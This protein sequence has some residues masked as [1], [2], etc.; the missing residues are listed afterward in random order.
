MAYV[1]FP[2]TGGLNTKAEPSSIADGQLAFAV[3]CSYDTVGAVSSG[4][5]R[6]VL[7]DGVA[8]AGDGTDQDIRGHFDAFGDRY[9]KSGTSV[10]K[11]Y[12]ESVVGAEGDW[13]G[14]THLTGFG[15]GQYVYLCGG[16]RTARIDP[17]DPDTPTTLETWGLV[18]PGYQELGA[19]PITITDLVPPL[20]NVTVTTPAAHGLSTYMRV[21]LFGLTDTNGIPNGELNGL[22]SIRVT[23]TT[24]YTFATTTTASAASVAGGGSAAFQKQAPTLASPAGGA[25]TEGTY[26]Y[27]YT[28]YNGMA[29][30]NFSAIMSE[31]AALNDLGRLTDILLG[32]EGT[33]ERRIYRSDVGGSQLYYVGTLSDNTTTTYDDLGAKPPHASASASPGDAVKDDSRPGGPSDEIRTL[34]VKGGFINR[35]N[36]GKPSKNVAAQEIVATNLGYLA[37]WTNHDAPP[38]DL[39]GVILVND[40]VIGISGNEVRFSAVGNPEHWPIENR[41]IPG[42]SDGETLL[43]VKAFDRDVIIYT[44]SGL[45]RLTQLGT[46]FE[47]SR[48]EAI[49]SPVGTT[50]K[51]GVAVLDGQQGHVFIANTGL[52]LFDGQR[53]QEA[54]LMFDTLFNG[55]RDP[56]FSTDTV[57]STYSDT[58]ILEALRD[59]VFVSYGNTSANSRLLIVDYENIQDPKATIVRQALTT[60]VR[61]RASNKLIGG[62]SSGKLYEMDY[63][64]RASYYTS[65]GVESSSVVDM[66]FLTK[67]YQLN[68]GAGF[69]LDEVTLDCDLDDGVF[70]FNVIV[71]ARG[72]ERYLGDAGT[73]YITNSSRGRLK[74]K[75]PQWMIGESVWVYLSSV[76]GASDATVGRRLF[77][78][79][80]F[81]YRPMGEP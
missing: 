72:V 56:N 45:Y 52:Y 18:A 28:F 10:Y 54:S 63:G 21:E 73:K 47:D 40:Q 55:E 12:D 33:T 69:C 34:R 7:N 43:C 67:E 19:D 77:Y 39:E 80:G 66:E 46:S 60:L 15:Y 13:D 38:T 14:S 68:G 70:L 59:K 30:S 64:Y 3:G 9:T 20:H 25:L 1:R 35:L 74:F 8:L 65:G 71:R 51:R 22:Q 26:K 31:D 32:P 42:K 75:M 79:I 57:V 37:D 76:N 4:R 11:N 17:D 24:T 62:S 6:L 5:G 78:S 23:S 50:S 41:I 16:G 48:F 53:V 49:E 2:L 81:T 61:E 29:E 36:R 58:A 27:A 44:D